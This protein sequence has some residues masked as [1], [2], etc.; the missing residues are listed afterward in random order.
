MMGWIRT[1]YIDE[2]GNPLPNKEYVI[3]LLDGTCISGI[4]DD[5]G[6]AKENDLKHGKYYIVFKE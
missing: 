3:Y 5:S 2:N 6:Y 1:Q 4:T